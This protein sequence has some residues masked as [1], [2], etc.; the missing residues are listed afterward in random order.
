MDAVT[1]HAA[2]A[3]HRAARRS[4]SAAGGLASAGLALSLL[5]A[6]CSSASTTHTTYT[7]KVTSDDGDTG[8][9]FL[10][11]TWNSS[12]VSKNAPAVTIPWQHD[13]QI[14]DADAALLSAGS[15]APGVRCTIVDQ[16]TG[17]VVSTDVTTETKRTAI[18][19]IS[20]D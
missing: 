18:C 11:Y 10:S 2:P 7:Y 6:G 17:D 20:A 13:F 8:T 1:E 9:F 12:E 4:A 16:A 5:L 14:R 19:R 3:R 15:L